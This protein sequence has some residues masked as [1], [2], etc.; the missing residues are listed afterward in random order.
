MTIDELEV[1]LDQLVSPEATEMMV[2]CARVLSESGLTS[3]LDDLEDLISQEDQIGR[4]VTV[5]QIRQYLTT[6]L[7]SC[8]IQFGVEIQEDIEINLRHLTAL[9]R[10]INQITNYED[11][12][13]LEALCLAES[14]PEER[15]ADMLELLTEYT[16]ADYSL[17]ID[18]VSPSLFKRILEQI[19][20]PDE[21][22]EHNTEENGILVRTRSLLVQVQAPWLIDEIEDGCTLGLPT[23]AMLLRFKARYEVALAQ[24]LEWNRK[25][26]L[27]A[28]QFLLYILASNCPDDQLLAT[29]Q[30]GA[31][32]VIHHVPTLS[33]MSRALQQLLSQVESK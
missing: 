6:T 32:E 1:Y 20:K 28:E 23:D 18:T 26:A 25:P 10:G 9:Q 27:L 24:S 11:V 8:V 13:A 12:E 15:F 21:L 4:D 14:D 17:L 31:E 3:H 19:T 5:I 7:E 30:A 16:W 33:A 22:E 29:A 2:D